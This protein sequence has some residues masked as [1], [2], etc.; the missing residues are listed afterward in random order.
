MLKF[1]RIYPTL[2]TAAGGANGKL[3]FALVNHFTK[4]EG[5]SVV[6]YPSINI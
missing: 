2:S 3:M 5:Y 4:E 6:E 1:K